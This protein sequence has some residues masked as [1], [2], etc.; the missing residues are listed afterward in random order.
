M[1]YLSGEYLWQPC[2]ILDYC[3]E[4]KKY[5]IQFVGS[6]EQKKVIRLNIRLYSE[7]HDDFRTRQNV[8]RN[9]MQIAKNDTN[10]VK[11]LDR[12]EDKRVVSLRPEIMDRIVAIVRKNKDIPHFGQLMQEVQSNYLL[13]MKKLVA[14][15]DMHDP[16]NQDLF[17]SLKL[18]YTQAKKQVAK[19]GTIKGSQAV[20]K[21]NFKR[22]KDIVPN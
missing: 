6:Q 17:R 21:Y 19:F 7:D 3:A 14:I 16:L 13:H 8:A 22:H 11:Y 4:A 15:S 12:I 1:R 10:F 9:M 5:T 18:E 2:E 20:Y